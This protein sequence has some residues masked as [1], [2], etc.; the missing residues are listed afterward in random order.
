MLLATLALSDLVLACKTRHRQYSSMRMGNPRAPQFYTKEYVYVATI[1]RY[2][3][4]QQIDKKYSGTQL[5][6]HPSIVSKQPPNL[7]DTHQPFSRIVHHC[8]CS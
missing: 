7:A 1:N 2:E 5:S 6:G 3:I 8:Y 4:T